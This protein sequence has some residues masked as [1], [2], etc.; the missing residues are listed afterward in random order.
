[1]TLLNNQLLSWA[2]GRAQ[3]VLYIYSPHTQI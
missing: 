2:C 1:V 3:G